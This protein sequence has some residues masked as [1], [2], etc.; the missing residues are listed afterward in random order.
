MRE[1]DLLQHIFAQNDALPDTVSVPPGDDMGA[2]RIGDA[3]VLVTVD[4]LADGVHFESATTPLARIGRKAITRNLSDVAAMAAV[5]VGA[6]AAACL[7]KSFTEAD[8]RTLCDALRDTA[9]QYN[10]PLIGGDVSVWDQPMVISVTVFAEPGGIDPILRSGATVGDV[11]CVTGQVGGAWAGGG[12]DAHHLTFE[13]RIGLAR[14]LAQLDGVR[15]HSM[16]D[17]SDG[18]ATDLA[19]ICRMSGVHAE[20]FPD[21]LPLRD[22]AYEAARHDPRPA[23]LHG[24]TDGEDYELC[25]TIDARAVE[26]ALPVAIDG[27]PITPIGLIIQKQGDDADPLWIRSPGGGL[28]PLEHAGWEHRT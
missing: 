21:R 23:W 24:L 6:V 10:C 17:L 28:T 3:T 13:P 27:V 19:H 25:F 4:Q 12:A 11:V 2:V 18:I 1:L 15:I 14:Q 20:V 8:A 16:I 26:S 22:S 5:P 7:P 9:A